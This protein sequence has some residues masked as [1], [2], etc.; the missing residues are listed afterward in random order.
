MNRRS[1]IAALAAIPFFGKWVPV[2]QTAPSA[3]PMATSATSITHTYSIKVRP[4][5][6]TEYMSIPV[7][8]VKPG[9]KFHLNGK[10]CGQ[11]GP[12]GKFQKVT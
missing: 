10:F 12:D 11:M 8:G 6:H 4:L 9:D 7:R 2:S 1:F 3:L 5:D